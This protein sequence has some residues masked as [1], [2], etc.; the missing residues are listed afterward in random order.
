[1]D[2]KY[3]IEGMTCGHCA[4]HVKDALEKVNGISN[5]KVNHKSGE[6]VITLGTALDIEILKSAVGET[7]YTLVS[8]IS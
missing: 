7:G 4:M 3:S 1:M 5:A 8:E 6:A 2:K